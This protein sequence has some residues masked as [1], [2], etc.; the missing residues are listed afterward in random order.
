MAQILGRMDLFENIS[1]HHNCS[2]YSF[3]RAFCVVGWKRPIWRGWVCNYYSIND[4]GWAARC[5]YVKTLQNWMESILNYIDGQHSNGFE[6]GVN[7]K[8][9]MIHRRAYCYRNFQ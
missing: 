8:I 5:V 9:K 7:L 2:G 1:I 6:D 4:D 3:F